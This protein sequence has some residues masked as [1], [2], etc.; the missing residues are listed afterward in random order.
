M[1]FEVGSYKVRIY[2]QSVPYRSVQ[3]QF[4][5]VESCSSPDAQLCTA[6]NG[7]QRKS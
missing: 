7:V 1:F 5:E 4:G 2:S 3:P 6:I